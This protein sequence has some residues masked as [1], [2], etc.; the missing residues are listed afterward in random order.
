MTLGV[1]L[2]AASMYYTF[3]ECPDAESAKD[4]I[5]TAA[6]IGSMYCVAGLSAIWYPGSD[7]KDPEHGKGREQLYLFSA[8]PVAVWTAYFLEVQRL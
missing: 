3:R 5:F 6:V 4:S 2:T 7:W 1:L 8:L